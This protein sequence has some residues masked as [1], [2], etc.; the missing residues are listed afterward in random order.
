MEMSSFLPWHLGIAQQ[1]LAERERFAHAWLIHGLAGIGKREFARSAAASLLCES[2]V[3]GL[4]CGACLACGWVK[5]GHHPD[6]KLIRPESIALAEGAEQAD[7]D[8][9][10][11]S[12]DSG[13]TTKKLPSKEIRI[14]QIR[15]L[16]NWFNTGT[17]RAGLRVVLIYPAQALNAISANA[18]L[19]VL[20][21]PAPSTVFLLVADAPDRLLATLLSRC[22]RLPL[23]TPDAE[24]SL[25]W[26][27]ANGVRDARQ[28]L[29]AAGGAPVLAKMLSEQQ[30]SACPDWLAQLVHGLAKP[31]SFD[32]GAM[33]D[34]LAKLSPVDWLDSLG[35]LG[36]DLVLASQGLSV[37]YFLSL[38]QPVTALA[39]S[40]DPSKLS[41]LYAW[42]SEQRRLATHPLNGK[43]FAQSVIQRLVVTTRS[44][45]KS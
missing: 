22:R 30:T 15:S 43:L 29:A 37:R 36:V 44:Q 25:S 33:A 2:T 5:L 27:E 24:I 20:E 42:L 31:S 38:T 11:P 6:L 7:S 28:W 18:L 41:D 9:A 39:A 45:R 16:E 40:S 26:L 35:R 1:W 8:D 10:A 3:R 4:A 14:E 32:V 34:I 21:E 19:K 13:S 17:H 23:P 12:S